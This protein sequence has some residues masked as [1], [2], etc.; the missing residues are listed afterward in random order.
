MKATRGAVVALNYTLTDDEG[1]LID[2]SEEPLE[3]LH[4]YDNIIPGLE[5]GLEGAEPGQRRSVVV[6]PAEAYG[7]TDP[8]A[9]I[10]VSP[11]T[12]TA[13]TE[14]RAPA[15]DETEF[16]C[17]FPSYGWFTT[18]KFAGPAGRFSGI[19]MYRTVAVLNPGH[20]GP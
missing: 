19:V 20:T 11:D 17:T 1:E 6:E 7:E 5:K 2:S 10:T 12:V 3:Y 8:D 16:D 13:L 9:I 18:W 14:R 4:G 15:T